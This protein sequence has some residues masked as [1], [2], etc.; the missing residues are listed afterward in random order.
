MRPLQ[1]FKTLP[2]PLRALAVVTAIAAFCALFALFI[3]GA[4]KLGGRGSV[5]AAMGLIMDA[6]GRLRPKIWISKF[7]P[8]S[9]TLEGSSQYSWNAILNAYKPSS[10]A[11][12]GS[13]D[14]WYY[15]DIVTGEFSRDKRDLATRSAESDWANILSDLQASRRT[16]SI[17]REL[18]EGLV[19]DTTSTG[20]NLVTSSRNMLQ[21]LSDST[22][23]VEPSSLQWSEGND[24]SY[25]QYQHLRRHFVHA[26]VV[27]TQTPATDSKGSDNSAAKILKID[28]TVSHPVPSVDMLADAP[29]KAIAAFQ[30]A[31]KRSHR[32][33][34]RLT[35]D[36]TTASTAAPT[37][38]AS[39]LHERRAGE[40]NVDADDPAAAT[41]YKWPLYNIWP[42][43]S[44]IHAGKSPVLNISTAIMSPSQLPRPSSSSS[45]TSSS[46]GSSNTSSVLIPVG[47]TYIHPRKIW[48]AMQKETEAYYQR[49]A[50]LT[51]SDAALFLP[52]IT[53]EAHPAFRVGVPLSE[54]IYV[55][56]DAS[57]LRTPFLSSKLLYLDTANGGSFVPS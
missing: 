7:P 48:T 14:K 52:P 33:R 22:M 57:T 28:P 12:S 45:S 20:R 44:L 16:T 18:K 24:W 46:S 25:Q 47:T 13:G 15:C 5:S 8:P 11:A 51:R 10:D 42:L 56:S 40:V 19:H 38:S 9:T 43:P 17:N 30:K 23:A 32:N 36:D 37:S 53:A 41:V 49:H 54:T 1:W 2:P 27:D 39:S 26:A 4:A 50:P 29:I 31:V 34:R 55:D 6:Y 21:S 3:N 35:Q